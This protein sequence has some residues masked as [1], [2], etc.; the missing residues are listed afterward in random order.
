MSR[1]F[2]LIA[3]HSPFHECR[4]LHRFGWHPSREKAGSGW[5]PVSKILHCCLPKKFGPCL[6][7]NVADHPL[8]SAKDHRLGV[9]FPLQLPNPTQAH[10]A[11]ACAFHY[12][13]VTHSAW[14]ILTRYA[15]VR[16]GTFTHT[17]CM[18]HT[19]RTRSFW[20]R[21]I[22][23]CIYSYYPPHTIS[24]NHPPHTG[25]GASSVM[26]TAVAFHHTHE[27]GHQASCT[28]H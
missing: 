14:Q 25:G 9:P 13:R 16:H 6:S 20:A 1:G 12:V 2:T 5:R 3:G 19:S 11:A 7:P 10:H 18:C 4:G 15:P 23:I 28:P 26:H 21:I 17:T 8:R 24:T 27:G 22:P